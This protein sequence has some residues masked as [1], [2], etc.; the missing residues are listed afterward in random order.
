MYI[1]VHICPDAKR[2]EVVKEAPDTW[3][4]SVREPAEGNRAND[5]M[6]TVI[7]RELAV[8]TSAVRILT[9]HHARSKLLSVDI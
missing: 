2:E 3:R 5:R 8:P 6:R 1:R 7:A 4:I 9:G